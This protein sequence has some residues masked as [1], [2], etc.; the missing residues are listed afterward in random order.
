[1][2]AG[3]GLIGIL[4]TIGII[5]V[6]I[7]K[8]GWFDNTTSKPVKDAREQA[9]QI[10]GNS[11]DGEMKF[12]D[13][14]QLEPESKGGKISSIAVTDVT[15]GGPAETYFGLKEGDAI[16]GYALNGAEQNVRDQNDAELV[17]AQIQ[18][19]YSQSGTVTVMRN[20][21][22]LTLPTNKP[23]GGAAQA[24]KGTKNAHDEI[25]QQIDI[26]QAAPGMP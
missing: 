7:G 15:A 20:G 12:K 21:K 3:F 6:L 18:T 17:I 23:A 1:M 22:R 19:A 8:G 4:V 13:S 10:A 9:N 14:V 26:H 25:Q 5:A 24:A 16:V 11:K 2:R